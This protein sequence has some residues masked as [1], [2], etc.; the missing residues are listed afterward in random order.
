MKTAC[1]AISTLYDYYAYLQ[2][3]SSMYKHIGPLFLQVIKKLGSRF[4]AGYEQ[5]I[6]GSG[7]SHIEEVPFCIKDLIKLCF[8]GCSFDTRL[9]W[10]YIVVARHHDNRLEF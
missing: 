4:N 1:E 7:A 2:A 8:I 3:M 9:Q 10:Q 5:M 6:P